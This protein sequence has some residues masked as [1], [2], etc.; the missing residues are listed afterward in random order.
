MARLLP[1]PAS[2]LADVWRGLRR[3]PAFLGELGELAFASAF[4]QRPPTSCAHRLRKPHRT[5]LASD[6]LCRETAPKRGL[7][8]SP[9]A[10]PRQT[11][12]R[13]RRF[14]TAGPSS[15]DAFCRFDSNLAAE[16]GSVALAFTLA[17]PRLAPFRLP[18]ASPSPSRD[19]EVASTCLASRAAARLPPPCGG[20]RTHLDASVRERC[21]SPTSATDLRH[22]HPADCMIPAHAVGRA[23]V[24][25]RLTAIPQLRLPSPTPRRLPLVGPVRARRAPVS[26]ARHALSGAFVVHV[27]HARHVTGA[28]APGT[29]RES[30]RA[31]SVLA[32]A[33]AGRPSD[34]R[35]PDRGVL[36]R[37]TGSR[38]GL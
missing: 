11:P 34:E 38:H 27:R 16:A 18:R 32:G 1:V 24:E 2:A 9:R 25:S 28:E 21:V 23:R 29:K 17:R 12:L 4:F 14:R 36:F 30:R 7:H 5:T 3:R 6:A 37:G 33:A 22:E 26:R 10:P 19:R 15:Q 31:P 20:E 35:S 8:S 13:R